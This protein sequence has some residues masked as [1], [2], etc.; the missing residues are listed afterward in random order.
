MKIKEVCQ[1]T[2]LTERTVRFYVE[3]GL[4]APDCTYQNG[5][6]YREYSLEDVTRLEQVAVLRRAGFSIEEIAS[7]QHS[8]EAVPEIASA[9]RARLV[10]MTKFNES[11]LNVAQELDLS[12]LNFSTLAM[13]LE[14]AS[15]TR[16]LPA[17]DIDINFGR[18]DGESKEEREKKAA[19]FYEK[20]TRMV[21]HGEKMVFIFIFCSALRDILV[22]VSSIISG[23]DYGSSLGSTLV[24]VIIDVILYI[25]LYQGYNWSRIILLVF[26]G[27]GLATSL[28]GLFGLYGMG[29]PWA[30]LLITMFF[31]Y[32]IA[33]FLI[34]FLSKDIREFLD[35]MKSI[36]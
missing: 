22:I 1:R 31:F 10:Q 23:G 18:L 6:E 3:K 17:S 28:P 11:L 21:S 29:I 26:S 24:G 13:K 2:G 9:W 27:L 30:S 16:S 34:L 5:R 32:D 25:M 33:L 7:M 35:Y 8:S 15:H 19:E 14:A 12:G 36:R 4:A 20:Q